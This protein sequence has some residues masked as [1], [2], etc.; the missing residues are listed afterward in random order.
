VDRS[1][2]GFEQ[3]VRCLIEEFGADVNQA[4][5]DGG[6]ALYAAACGGHEHVVQ[7]LV[8]E[9]GADVNQAGRDGSASLMAAAEV[10]HEHVVRCLVKEFGA[11]VNLAT[12]YGGTPLMA[13]AEGKHTN[14]ARTPRHHMHDSARRQTFRTH[15]EPRTGRPRTWRHAF[16]APSPDAVALGSRSAGCLIIFYCGKECQVAHWPAHKAKR[17]RSAGPRE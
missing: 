5:S 13:A 12:I 17:K 1:P 4:T 15:L 11:D 7:C 16:T 10:G 9:F 8:K 3:V 6:T 14:M 2:A